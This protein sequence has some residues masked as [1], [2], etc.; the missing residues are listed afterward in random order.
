MV[1]W[2]KLMEE[3]EAQKTSQERSLEAIDK[4]ERNIMAAL[5]KFEENLL[6]RISGPSKSKV[7]RE[8]CI[9]RQKREGAQSGREE[10]GTI[11]STN[12]TFTLWHNGRAQS[13]TTC[14]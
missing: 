13:D 8:Q 14:P 1:A 4:C 12:D 3:R 7:S 2:W 11:Q 9:G 5:D 10:I 6:R